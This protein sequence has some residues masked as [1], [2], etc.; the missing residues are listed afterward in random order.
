MSP[1]HDRP[2]PT[3]LGPNEEPLHSPWGLAALAGADWHAARWYPVDAVRRIAQLNLAEP[4]CD[5]ARI[6]ER[7]DAERLSC[8]GR[9]WTFEKVYRVLG[10]V[11]PYDR[12]AGVLQPNPGYLGPLREDV[13][14]EIVSATQSERP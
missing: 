8:R 2:H 7:L 4:G 12:W 3:V 10:L 13:Q 6:A 1:T 5:L 9:P 11:W 14:V